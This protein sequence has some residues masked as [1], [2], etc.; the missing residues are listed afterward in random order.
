MD[1]VLLVNAWAQKLPARMLKRVIGVYQRTLS[2]DH[3]PLKF[4]FP[5]GV[6]KYHPTCS[7]YAVDALEEWGAFRGTWMAT[8]RIWRCNPMSNGGEDPVPKRTKV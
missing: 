7:Q 1:Y 5:Y 2:P 4:L 3:G 8:K 6:C